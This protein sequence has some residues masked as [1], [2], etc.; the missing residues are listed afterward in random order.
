MQRTSRRRSVGNRGVS[1]GQAFYGISGCLGE[2]PLVT[3]SLVKPLVK[4]SLARKDRDS[5]LEFKE[6]KKLSNS[7][8]SSLARIFSDSENSLSQEKL[9][10]VVPQTLDEAAKEKPKYE[11]ARRETL[12]QFTL[13]RD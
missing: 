13:T 8:R 11:S 7:K 6:S 3:D 10:L 9:L 2:T 4:S 5:I 1:R 12:G